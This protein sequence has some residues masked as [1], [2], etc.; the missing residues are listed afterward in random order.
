MD[1]IVKDS[2]D[3]KTTF[4]HPLRVPSHAIEKDMMSMATLP[5]ELQID[6]ILTIIKSLS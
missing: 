2:L 1:R 5:L 6:A 3:K 4:I